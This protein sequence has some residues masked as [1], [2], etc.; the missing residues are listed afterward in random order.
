MTWQVE[1]AQEPPQ[2]PS[3]SKLL[4]CAMSSK[5]SPSATSKLSSSPVLVMKVMCSSS[6]GLGLWR[7]PWSR[8]RVYEMCRCWG[9]DS[10]CSDGSRRGLLLGSATRGNA[11]LSVRNGIAN[12]DCSKDLNMAESAREKIWRW[13]QRT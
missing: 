8:G 3:I 1:H 13:L 5:L 9:N 6:P 11:Q 7:W 2:A 12:R 10:G 4:A